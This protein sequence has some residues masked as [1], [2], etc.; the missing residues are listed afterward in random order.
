MK[1]INLYFFIV[2]VS[3]VNSYAYESINRQQVNSPNSLISYKINNSTKNSRPLR[4]SIG[5]SWKYPKEAV[6]LFK[7]IDRKIEKLY[8]A[9]AHNQVKL[10]VKDNSLKEKQ[11]NKITEAIKDINNRIAELNTSK[12][13]VIRLG[14]DVEH[15]YDLG[16]DGRE[17]G[18]YSILKGKNNQIKIQG[19]NDAQILHEIRHVSLS[20]Q[21][22]D[23]LQFSKNNLLMP[24]AADGS[25]DELQG[26][27]AQYAFQPNSLPG[28]CPKDIEHVDLKYICEIHKDNGT[29]AYPEIRKM[30]NVDLRI[31][32]SKNKID[33]DKMSTSKT[34]VENK[35]KSKTE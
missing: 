28:F 27:R 21:S 32:K 25:E 20:L 23:G 4:T 5:M 6:N 19:L 10:N 18:T 26:Y 22:P 15:I 29:Y 1:T 3:F 30:L 14:N 8:R 33:I 31:T 35:K 7:K 2:F 34:L 9:K 13:D 16:G 24:I 12:A 17:L 11:K